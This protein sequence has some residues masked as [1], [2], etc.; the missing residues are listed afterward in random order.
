MPDV[1]TCWW[2]AIVVSVQGHVAIMAYPTSVRGQ[3]YPADPSHSFRV[4]SHWDPGFSSWLSV[5]MGP[6]ADHYQE[7]M[8][9]HFSKVHPRMKAAERRGMMPDVHEVSASAPTGTLSVL[10]C[11]DIC[12]LYTSPSPRD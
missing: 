6:F 8:Y 1:Q 5:W 2:L 10:T 12:L 7:C 3:S 4:A 11:T 9:H